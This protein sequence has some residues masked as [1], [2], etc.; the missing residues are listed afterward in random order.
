MRFSGHSFIKKVAD[1]SPG[2]IAVYDIKTGE[3]LY[4]NSAIRKILGYEPEDFLRGGFEFV[5]KLVHP[6][7]LSKIVEKNTEALNWANSHPTPDNES[8]INFEY[9][10]Q[11]KDGT[12]RW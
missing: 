3:Y 4:V 1:S 9:R 12:Y 5:V 7:D 10:M 6:D 8:I 11:H 2:M